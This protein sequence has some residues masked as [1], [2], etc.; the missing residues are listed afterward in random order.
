[1]AEAGFNHSSL[2]DRCHWDMGLL[3]QMCYYGS[4]YHNK[5]IPDYALLLTHVDIL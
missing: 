3:A 5:N 1:M 4:G 2:P